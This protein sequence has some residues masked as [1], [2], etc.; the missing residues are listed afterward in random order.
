MELALERVEFLEKK[1]KEQNEER[2]EDNQ[3]F[4]QIIGKSKE[5]FKNLFDGK[6]NEDKDEDLNST[7][8]SEAG[9]SLTNTTAQSFVE[10]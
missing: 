6:G 2:D 5:L 10:N 9:V 8:N 4:M 7:L 1:I 3:R